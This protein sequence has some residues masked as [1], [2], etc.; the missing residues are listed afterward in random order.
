MSNQTVAT[1]HADVCAIFD[2]PACVVPPAE[3]GGAPGT[4]AWLRASVSRFCT[5]ADHDR[6]RSLI[7]RDLER[8]DPGRLRAAALDRT[9]AE[10]RRAAPGPLDVM[11]R[12]ARPVPVAVLGAELGVGRPDLDLLVEAVATVGAAYHPATG[13]DERP[14][15]AAVQRLVRLL[16][17]EPTEA[18]ANRIA[19]PVQACDATARLVCA[20][21]RVALRLP[22]G[23]A[24][25]WP[26]EALVAETLRHDP[27]ARSTRRLRDGA[28]VLLDLASANR[29][30]AVF[31]DPHRFDPGRRAGP[32]LAYGHGPRACPGAAQA[33][34]LACGV[35]EAVLPRATL[36]RQ[37]PLEVTIR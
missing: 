6:R 23:C 5:G 3:P 31:G 27:P 22:P 19:L 18:A 9:L 21:L 10:L 17:P 1:R 28:T 20:A 29:D 2:D 35:V 7:E 11:V 32:H 15:D 24:E 12:L 8:M 33:T 30:P 34:A 37:E 25:R 13:A 26:V 4:L 14:A 16:G 36:A